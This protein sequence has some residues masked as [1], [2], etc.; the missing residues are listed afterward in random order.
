M[1]RVPT[2]EARIVAVD[3]GAERIFLVQDCTATPA[4][5]R[6]HAKAEET[7]LGTRTAYLDPRI[8]DG[9]DIDKPQ[10]RLVGTVPQPRH[11]RI[12]HFMS[13]RFVLSRRPFPFF[14]SL[15]SERLAPHQS[16]ASATAIAAAEAAKTGRPRAVVLLLGTGT[17]NGAGCTPEEV[18]AY[19]RALR[20][21]LFVWRSDPRPAS[22]ESRRWGPGAAVGTLRELAA[23]SNTVRK[24]VRRQRTVWIEGTWLPN[25]ITLEDAPDGVALAGASS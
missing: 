13:N 16:L 22:R 17:D 9:S 3:D 23:N 24:F 5:R 6:A 4:M 21:P 8:A 10:I 11:G 2:G 1:I 7:R 15:P 19:M 18:I 25:E 20:V 12:F 14:A